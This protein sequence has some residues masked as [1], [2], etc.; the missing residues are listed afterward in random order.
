MQDERTALIVFL[1]SR[2]VLLPEGWDDDTS[3]VRSGVLDSLALL[4]L[5]IW[6]EQR[7]GRPIDPTTFELGDELDTIRD[8]L[9]FLARP[10]P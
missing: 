8:I 5:I 2:D 1:K 3:L 7:L 6:L 9:E 4:E 10:I